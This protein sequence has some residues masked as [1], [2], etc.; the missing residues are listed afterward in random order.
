MNFLSYFCSQTLAFYSIV[1]VT[2]H[3]IYEEIFYHQ[4]NTQRLLLFNSHFQL[5]Y[6]YFGNIS[7]SFD[8]VNVK[9]SSLDDSNSVP[10]LE[11][12]WDLRGF[13]GLSFH[14]LNYHALSSKEIDFTVYQVVLQRYSFHCERF[15]CTAFG[16]C[17]CSW[18]WKHY[19]TDEH[20]M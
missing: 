8:I 6:N 1:L 5:T 2:D 15:I 10:K 18:N 9:K 13:N 19:C 14:S 16:I 4:R 17:I 11:F 7:R 3:Y 12:I 20:R